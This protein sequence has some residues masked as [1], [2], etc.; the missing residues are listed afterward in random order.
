MSAHH[1]GSRRRAC[2]LPSTHRATRA[3]VRA[4][5][6]RRTSFTNPTCLRGGAPARNREL[7]RGNQRQSEPIRAN[8]SQAEPIRANQGLTVC[9]EPYL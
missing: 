3:R 2:A 7:I 4:T 1:A 6:M 8:Q 9:V 5:F